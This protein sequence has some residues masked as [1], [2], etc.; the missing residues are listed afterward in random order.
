M[1]VAIDKTLNELFVR[2]FKDLT[3]IEGK[4][5]ITEEY[6]DITYNDMHIIETIGVGMPR[7][8]SEVARLMSIT[9]GTLTKAVDALTR[10]GYVNRNRDTEDKRVIKLV[11]TD[12]G[13]QAYYHHESFHQQ[14]IEHIK[15]GMDENSL[16]ITVGALH[17]MV[18]YFQ[19]IYN[20]E[21]EEE[22][23]ESWDKIEK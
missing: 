19:S 7:K 22:Q 16:M 15:D 8:M 23:F 4:A 5:L 14:M 11:L 9:T 20:R 2:L 13:R 10:K 3:E 12:K 6:S 1:S 17:R 18:D 21:S